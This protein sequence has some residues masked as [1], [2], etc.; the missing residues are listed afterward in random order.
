MGVIES[1]NGQIMRDLQKID[2]LYA[3]LKNLGFGYF[4]KSHK[5][6]QDVKEKLIEKLSG[7][8]IGNNGLLKFE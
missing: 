5:Y 3:E 7:I 2:L 6:D 4:S 8:L 1:F